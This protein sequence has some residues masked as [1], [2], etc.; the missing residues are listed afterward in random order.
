MTIAEVFNM[1]TDFQFA[2]LL[3]IL[4]FLLYG[5]TLTGGAGY[6]WDDRAAIIANGDVSGANPLSHIFYH[7]FWG[8]DIKLADSHKSFR[9]ITVLS[10]RLNYWL[11]G[12]SAMGFH[13]LNIVIYA[14]G[15]IVYYHWAKQWSSR[16]ISRFAALL[17]CCHPI[18]VEAVASLVGRADSLCGLFYLL[19]IYL[20]TK[21]IR[22]KQSQLY[23][24]V[25]LLVS[26][27]IALCA[28]YSKEIGV[29]S[30]GLFICLEGLEVRVSIRVR[31]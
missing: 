3:F 8:Q 19:A 7:D 4:S 24:I 28:C 29:T 17:Y 18:H 26:Y 20:Y 9:P 2:L 21:S 16:A 11:H 15:V 22:I 12:Y 6:V 5:N 14:M 23:Q 10:F 31:G 25:T 13:L 27:I 1:P 30:F